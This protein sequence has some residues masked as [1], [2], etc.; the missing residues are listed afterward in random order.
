MRAHSVVAL[1]VLGGCTFGFDRTLAPGELRGRVVADQAVSGQVQ[2]LPAVGAR[3]R[4]ANSTVALRTD[5]DGR[6]VFRRLGAGRYGLRF[7]FDPENDGTPEGLLGLRDLAVASRGS[8]NSEGKDIGT[9]Q[10]WIAGSVQGRVMLDGLPVPDAVLTVLDSD[11]NPELALPAVR[12]DGAGRFVLPFVPARKVVVRTVIDRATALGREVVTSLAAPVDVQPRARVTADLVLAAPEA[13][14]SGSLS[15]SAAGSAGLDRVTVRLLREG[16]TPVAAE[17]LPADTFAIP[18]IPAGIYTLVLS[19]TGYVDVVLPD[20]AVHGDVELDTVFFAQ[21]ATE[22]VARDCNGDGVPACD[23]DAESEAC[24]PDDDSDGITDIEESFEC[25]CRPGGRTGAEGECGPLS[26][27]VAGTVVNLHATPSGIVPH[28]VDR[29]RA[30][31]AALVRDGDG[32]R[33]VEG[34]GQADG[35][36]RV[37]GVPA[38]PFLLRAMDG[39]PEYFETDR[40]TLELG[41]LRNGRADVVPLDHENTGATLEFALTGMTP[42]K[43]GDVI[44]AYSGGSDSWIWWVQNCMPEQPA[45]GAT[46]LSFTADC[47]GGC[48]ARANGGWNLVEGSKGDRLVLEHLATRTSPVGIPYVAC[49]ESFQAPAFDQTPG[50]TQSFAGAFVPI[51]TLRTLSLELRYGEFEAMAGQ[52]GPGTALIPEGPAAGVVGQM[53]GVAEGIYGASA[54]YLFVQ[55]AA[56]GTV[57]TGPMQYGIPEGTGFEPYGLV[58]YMLYKEYTFPGAQPARVRGAGFWQYSDMADLGAAPVVPKQRPPGAPRIDDGDL[59]AARTI[60]TATPRLSW[61]A[62]VQGAPVRYELTVFRLFAQEGETRYETT[63]RFT[64]P[65]TELRLPSGVL[66]NGERYFFLLAAHAGSYPEPARAPRRTRLP[67]SSSA[68]L[69]EVVTVE[70]AQP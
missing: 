28:A 49:V 18:S 55:S 11:G 47:A 42:W 8:A 65:S 27:D 63:A 3:V 41:S 45:E 29:S 19:A 39:E 64:T 32:Y 62:P 58:Q 31:V 54:D 15:G 16:A 70:L 21:E 24:D 7:E 44:E 4:L 26:R 23:P 57:V 67:E 22:G 33:T 1:F 61:T 35:S 30:S 20:V 68:L 5:R 10:L 17:D 56:S 51:A 37:P 53:G 52:C 25:L 40:A 59:F 9:L 2:R 60:A 43:T 48:A 14:R 36:F 6:F 34:A 69:T 13:A 38:G 46:D 50:S 66:Q 12:S